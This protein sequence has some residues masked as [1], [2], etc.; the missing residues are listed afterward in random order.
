MV[1][2][3]LDVVREVKPRFWILENVKNAQRWLGRAPCHIGAFY[4]WGWF[5]FHKLN[6]PH[7]VGYFKW[8]MPPSANRKILRAK[9]PYELSLAVALVVEEEVA[10]RYTLFREIEIFAQ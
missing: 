6:L 9:V 10:E 3:V 2:A 7:S 5:P 8:K 1:K 4:M